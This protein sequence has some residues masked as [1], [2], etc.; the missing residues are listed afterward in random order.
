MKA[1]ARFLVLTLVMVAC[2]AHYSRSQNL[3]AMPATNASGT[4]PEYETGNIRTSDLEASRGYA[5]R[6][7]PSEHFQDFLEDQKEIW[8]SP[9]RVRFSDA[10]WLVPLGGLAAGLFA[11]DRQYSASLSQNP[12]TIRH[13]KNISNFGLASL[14]GASAGLYL[15][16]YP[17][18]NDHWRETGFLS[19]E[20]ALNSLVTVEALKYSLR[21]AR[22]DK[23]G[24]S[25]K[26]FS[27]GTSFPSEH[28]AVAWSIAG[29]IAHEYPGTLP[30]LFAYGMA[31]AVSFSRVHERQHF[32]SDA[33]IGS[34]IG[35]LIAQ[36]VFRRRHEVELGGG[37]WESPH[38][39]VSE[40]AMRTPSNMGSPYVP[41]D[42]WVYPAMERLAAFGYI[43][44]ASMGIRPW[45]RLECARLLGEAAEL[46]PDTDGPAEVQDLFNS[47]SEEFVAESSLMSG[48]NNV[49]AQLESVYQRTLGISGTPLTDAL[50]F[51][52]TVSNDYGRPFQEGLNTVGGAS[53]WATAGPF[54]IY[55]RGEYQHSPSAPAPSQ[56]VLGFISTVD[57]LPANAPSTP[58]ASTSRF[59]P[60][61]AYVGMNIG[62]WQLS[63]GRQSLWWGTA[64]SSA[65]LFTNNAAPLSKMFRVNR[66]SPFR[67][68]WILS[69][70]GDVRLDLFMGQLAGQQFINNGGLGTI[71]QGQ[72]GMNL[73]PQ[74]FLSG[75]KIS[76]KLTPNLEFN[77]SKTTIYGG[78]GN[79]LTAKTFL[80]ST[81][82]LHVNSEPLGDGRSVVDFSYRIPKLRNWVTLYG[83][84][85]SED[86]V[87]PLNTAEK[88]AWQGGLYFARF[89]KMPKLDMRIEGGFTNPVDFPTCNGC[90]YHNFQYVSGYTNDGQLIAS[91]IGRAAQGESIISNYWLSATKKIGVELRH[92][93]IDR[94][95]LPQGG[96]QTDAA[97]N[98][99]LLAKSGFRLSG[100]LQYERWQIPLVAAGP[101]SNISASFQFSFWP[102]V[103]AK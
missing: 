20:A 41:L 19:A 56:A 4:T 89:P 7:A 2:T 12:A 84:G 17:M 66:V 46:S 96:S 26:F 62:N 11:T 8:S 36:S 35:F 44:S 100:T 54:V 47:L 81:F 64:D 99:D 30:K 53:A 98:T 6:G 48:E 28:A 75:G 15:F 55:V 59:R 65:M 10:T 3:M 95:F 18:H 73:K 16:S 49:H 52:Q 51:G 25:G 70:L 14:V 69:H 93:K 72:Y 43:G 83:E 88:S 21:R 38:E 103:H 22:P 67:F 94:Q 57:G 37:A 63:F 27:D 68:P 74:P 32:A 23:D 90:F 60:L 1:S 91:G 87:I 78:P 101:Q 9:A 42:S 50:H 31:S 85:F 61:D 33:L 76:F 71:A 58:I 45:T 92:R 77:F 5:S 86:E 79:P 40:P 97:V 82:D 34:A 29:V 80:K 102:Q 39:F 13:Y 24:G